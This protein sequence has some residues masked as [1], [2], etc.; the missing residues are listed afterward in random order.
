M[1]STGREGGGVADATPVA[2]GV[3]TDAAG[4]VLIARRHDR[5][6]QGGKWEFPGGKKKLGESTLDALRRELH[7]ELGIAVESAC[8]L[9]QV[10]HAYPD[11]L[12]HLDVWRVTRFQGQPHGREGQPIRWVEVAELNTF[13]FPDADRPVLGALRL[14]S[15]Y[16]ITDSRP[17]GRIDFLQR[18]ERVLRAGARLIQLREPQLSLL[19]YRA[20]AREV[21]ELCHRHGAHVLLN[22]APEW[23]PEC[24]ADGVHLNSRRLA[25]ISTRPLDAHHW[26]AASCHDLAQVE[27]ARQLDV[28][29]I[30]VSPV[31]TTRSHPGATPLGWERFGTLCAAANMPVY[32]LG[33]M[34]PEDID[35]ARVAGAQGLA[36]ISGVWGAPEPEAVIAALS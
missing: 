3:V 13:E 26:V 16:V 29:F 7:E 18:L 6:H 36:M 25:S 17:F 15:L 2:V 31:R 5:S 23:V 14:P 22:A 12:V 10:R 27:R 9:I 11:K 1:P 20:Y 8:P 28:D 32:A 24:D 21:A 33:G 19:E 4:R 34:G 35:R 30:V